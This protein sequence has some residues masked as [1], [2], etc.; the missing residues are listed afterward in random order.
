M[1]LSAIA[2]DG[3]TKLNQAQDIAGVLDALK[4]DKA[5]VVAHDIGNIGTRF[6]GWRSKL[7]KVTSLKGSSNAVRSISK[8]D[9]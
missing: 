6:T 9:K 5:D 7:A 1:G 3:F 4:V 8:I 2:T